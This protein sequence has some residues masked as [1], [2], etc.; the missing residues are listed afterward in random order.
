MKKMMMALVV[1]CLAVALTGFAQEGM[2][3]GGEGKW[4]GKQHKGKQG[5]QI[6][7]LLRAADEIGLSDEQ[8]AKLKEMRIDFKMAAIERRAEVEKASVQ[9]KFLM[10]DPES[11]EREVHAAIER[12]A[13]LKA[14]MHKMKFSAHR[15]VTSLL[16][17]SQRDKIEARR[18]EMRSDKIERRKKP[19]FHDIQRRRGW[20]H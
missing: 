20:G 2:R 19:D 10:A 9:L 8:V 1:M 16:T 17:E 5:D 13:G 15:N 12:V 11:S 18:K 14:E 7:R 6:G 3:H 4:M